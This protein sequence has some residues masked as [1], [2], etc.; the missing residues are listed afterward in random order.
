MKKFIGL[1]AATA[2]MMTFIGCD[3]FEIKIKLTEQDI[4]L[5][6]DILLR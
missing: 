4:I 1:A 2:M 5:N 3:L 6:N